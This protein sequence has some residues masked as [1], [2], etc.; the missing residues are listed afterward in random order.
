LAGLLVRYGNWRASLSEKKQTCWVWCPYCRNE[1]T[2][3]HGG[4][5]REDATGAVV[6][7]CAGCGAVTRWDFDAPVPLLLAAALATKEMASA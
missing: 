1:L 5:W 6:Y 4:D 7:T 2:S 3:E